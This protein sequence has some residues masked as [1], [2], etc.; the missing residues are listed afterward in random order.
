MFVRKRRAPF[1]WEKKFDVGELEKGPRALVPLG[2]GSAMA[3]FSRG[4]LLN[5]VFDQP[6]ADTTYHLMV[7]LTDSE[8][9]KVYDAPPEVGMLEPVRARL[10]NRGAVL[11]VSREGVVNAR[12][13]EIPGRGVEPEFVA[14]LMISAKA[15]SEF[16]QA[17]ELG[18]QAELARR[19][20]EPKPDAAEVSRLKASVE[21]VS[22]GRD[23]RAV[24]SVLKHA[25]AC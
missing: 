14:D 10:K 18:G 24:A 2:G 20:H 22:Q 7:Y 21:R 3:K 15:V 19:Q 16:K 11:F 6:D 13:Y 17:V 12:R 9:Q 25:F 5:W 4:A 23:D 8:S 1:A